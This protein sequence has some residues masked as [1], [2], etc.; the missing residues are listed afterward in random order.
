MR[1]EEVA[2]ALRVP[3]I[4]DPVD[5]P[6]VRWGSSAPGGDHLTAVVFPVR[7]EESIGRVT[8]EELDAIRVARG[9]YLPFEQRDESY[10]GWEWVYVVENSRWL[11]E[12]HRYEDHHYDSPLVESHDHYVFS[13]HD[14]FVEAIA[15]GI[16][17]DKPE[18]VRPF[19]LPATHPLRELPED[20][21][22][23]RSESFGVGWELRMNPTP[24]DQLIEA[25]RFCSQRLFQYNLILDGSNTEQATV[26][27]RTRRGMTVSSFVT[28]PFSKTR[29]E[30]PEVATTLT[31][32]QQW[33]RLVE[34]VAT[35]RRE[36]GLM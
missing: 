11:E 28:G 24:I 18:A 9:E 32:H 27:V 3:L 26:W 1:R 16:W 17:L 25:S 22:T 5:S 20:T 14:E 19:S 15:R 21:A 33:D 31:F 13:F 29:I 7:D 35:R 10:E 2:V 36:M 30:A 23:E 6:Q 8:F 34:G 12:R 4:A